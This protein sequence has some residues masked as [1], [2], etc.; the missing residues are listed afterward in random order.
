MH[1]SALVALTTATSV[2][3]SPVQQQSGIVTLQLK[4][5][6][7]VKSASEL[8]K[9]GKAR[10]VGSGAGENKASVAGS[11]PAENVVL[12]YVANVTVGAGTYELIVDTGSSNTWIGAN[13]AYQP[14]PKSKD[15]GH[16]IEVG[17]GSGAFEGE[18]YIDTVSIAGLTVASQGVGVASESRG[19]KAVDGIFGVGPVALT[20]GTVSDETTVPTFLDN[21]FEQHLIP[22]EVFSVYF[23][24]ETGSD[25][26]DVNGELAFGGAD[27]TKFSGPVS[28][29]P[30]QKSGAAADFWGIS[31]SFQ[32]GSKK[33]G[34]TSAG[35]VDTGTTLIYIPTAAFNAFL[36]ASGGVYDDQNTGLVRYSKKPTSPFSITLG[37]TTYNL[38][39]DEYLI[40]KSQYANLN[41]TDSSHYYAWINDGGNGIGLF[42]PVPDATIG[43]KFL[44]HYYSVYDTT[45]SRIGFAKAV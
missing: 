5:V 15:T 10:L 40:P 1:F 35:I 19:F 45:N 16:S 25:N 26:D 20:K 13:K 9:H 21:L 4:Q 32:Y 37:P 2:L 30:T 24:P 36:T 7:R 6:N 14:G 43:Q 11:A 22:K 29:V 31:A 23:H 28:Y 12:S 27:S 17:Y 42:G 41:I 39:P 18:E 33:L 38:T 3:A 34:Q 44:E 8:V